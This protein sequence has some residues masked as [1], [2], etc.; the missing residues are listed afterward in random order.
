MAT[1]GWIYFSKNDRDRIGSVLDQL[2][3]E[4]TIDELGMGT[5]RD[6]LSNQMFPGISTIQ[7]RAKYFFIIPYLLHDYQNDKQLQKKYKDPAKFLERKENE[8]MWDLGDYYRALSSDTNTRESYGVIGI[9]KT[10]REKDFIVRRPSAIYWNGLYTYQFIN[11]QGLATDSFLRQVTNPSLESL[12]SNVKRGDDTSG[13]D[14]D[15]EHENLFRLKVTPNLNWKEGLTLD[16]DQK[17][18][19]FF[20]DRIISIAKHKLIAELLQN[21]A[22]WAIALMSDNFMDFATT[23]L[24]TDSLPLP[25]SLRAMLVLAHDFSMLMYGA[26][27]AYNCQLQHKLNSDCFDVKFQ[28][29]TEQIGDLML[30]YDHFNPQSLFSYATTTRSNTAQFV[31]DWWQQTQLGFPDHQKRDALIEQQEAR[32]KGAK[33]RLRWNKLDLVKEEKWQGLKFFEY[34]FSRARTIVNDIKVGLNQ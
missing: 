20:Q 11:T 28:E 34:R 17:E 18:A 16:L 4:G 22:L 9:T 8:I 10:R 12:L 6:A 24:S 15:V 30:D 19:E 26:H 29:W 21:E 3:P 2:R 25:D 5:I 7:T 31:Q 14:L 32:V 27:L 1:I 13:D 23:A 33:A